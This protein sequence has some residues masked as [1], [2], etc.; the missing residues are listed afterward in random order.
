MFG[1]LPELS[2]Y[3]LL[4]FSMQKISIDI[5]ASPM[6]HHDIR[7]TFIERR[8][9]RFI[10]ECFHFHSIHRFN[11]ICDENAEE[12]LLRRCVSRI[13]FYLDEAFLGN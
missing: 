13:R 3:Q 6:T 10:H 2:V 11:L 5:I 12:S 4:R 1:K 8:V 9:L 7:L